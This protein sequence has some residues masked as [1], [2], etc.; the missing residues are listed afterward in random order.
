MT[1]SGNVKNDWT[2]Y[3]GKVLIPLLLDDPL[4]VKKTNVMKTSEKVL[5]PLLLDDPL[6]ALTIEHCNA[7]LEVLIPLLLDD[8][9]WESLYFLFSRPSHSLNP[10]F[11]G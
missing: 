8:P 5:I 11:A 3:I 4:W 1:H 6:W 10:S 2:K 9:L 7:R